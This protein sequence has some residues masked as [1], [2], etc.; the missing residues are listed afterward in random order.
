MIP[1]DRILGSVATTVVFE[2]TDMIR[3]YASVANTAAQMRLI[4]EVNEELESMLKSGVGRPDAPCARRVLT[5]S[6]NGDSC[7]QG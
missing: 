6:S 2:S 5:N 7:E 3:L 4:S 1:R